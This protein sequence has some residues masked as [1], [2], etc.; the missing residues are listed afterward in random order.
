[1][2]QLLTLLVCG[3]ILFASC[4]KDTTL[5]NSDT[6]KLIQNTWTSISSRLYTPNSSTITIQVKDSFQVF[7]SDGYLLD[8]IGKNINY[9]NLPP[10]PLLLSDTS[11]YTLSQD[12]S[13]LLFYPINDGI[14]RT[15][16]DTIIIRT[17]TDK[18]F[19]YYWNQGQGYGILDSLKK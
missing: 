10:L 7:R 15:N 11:T 6:L 2:K 18:L 8:C 9:P 13:T 14:K 19:V 17:I 1:M 5:S 4:K 16:A 3:L 12:N